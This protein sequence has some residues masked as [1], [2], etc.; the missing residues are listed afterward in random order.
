MIYINQIGQ[1]ELGR[2]ETL[3]EAVANANE[4]Y[5]DDSPITTDI[6]RQRAGWPSMDGDIV[7]C[8]EP[9][10]GYND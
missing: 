5:P 7:Y 9:L 2:G 6:R 10:E 8:D 4:N 1:T 3:E